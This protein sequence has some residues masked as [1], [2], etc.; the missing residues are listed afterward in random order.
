MMC[1]LDRE[2]FENLDGFLLR[3]SEL[4]VCLQTQAPLRVSQ[5][6]VQCKLGI[7]MQFRTIHG[8]EKEVAKS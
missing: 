5:A 2:L 7:A 6:V 1:G 4:L 8:L 3:N